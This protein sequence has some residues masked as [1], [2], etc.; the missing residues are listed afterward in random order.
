MRRLK[1]MADEPRTFAN[2]ACP[3]CSVELDP[4][5]TAKKLCTGCGQPIYVR[6]GPDGLIYLLQVGDLPVLDQAWI[7]YYGAERAHIAADLDAADAVAM[8][9]TLSDYITSGVRAVEHHAAEDAC[10]TCAALH[11]RRFHP[12]SAPPIPVPGCERNPCRCD[13]LPVV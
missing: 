13:Y 11:R 8:L 1:A 3:Y 12:R 10:P 6:L 7:E 9:R 5:P 2:T 4:L